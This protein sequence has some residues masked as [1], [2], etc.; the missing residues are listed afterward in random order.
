MNLNEIEQLVSIVRDARVSEL[1]VSVG[2]STVKLR[3]P[4]TP[5]PKPRPEA[6]VE[7]PKPET[8]PAAA[9]EAEPVETFI[10][11]PM[12]GIFHSIDS[13]GAI[14]SPVK[15]GQVVG[16]IESMKLMNDVVAGQDGVIA[17]ILI[18]DDMPVEYGQK[19][20]RIGNG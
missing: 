10:T 7:A 11:A 15:L 17:E 16:V 19:L 4:L 18:E 9:V 3:K 2:D 1:T 13:I 20:F 5:A 6:K 12:V 8:K 14:E